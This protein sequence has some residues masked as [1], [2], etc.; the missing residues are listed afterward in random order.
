MLQKTAAGNRSGFF[1]P[2]QQP[3]ASRISTPATLL[4]N[5]PL[6]RL[7]VLLQILAFGVDIFVRM[8]K[9]HNKKR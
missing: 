6:I 7:N 1:V 4:R 9:V 5:A 3:G 8:S 2:G